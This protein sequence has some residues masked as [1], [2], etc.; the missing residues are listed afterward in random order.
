MPDIIITPGRGL[1]DFYPSNKTAS[2][3][4]SGNDLAFAN[5]SGNFEF[6]SGNIG[7]GT[8]TPS[9]KLTVVGSGIFITLTTGL[10]PNA[11]LHAYSAVSGDT[12]FNAEGT[13]G[14]I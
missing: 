9:G 8:T 13:N 5:P 11:L 12:I 3:Y 6:I 4:T 1:I 10:L 14:S 2:I 7:I